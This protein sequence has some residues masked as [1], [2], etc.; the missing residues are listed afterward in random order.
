MS[1][2]SFAP[3][4]FRPDEALVQFKRQLRD[5]RPLAERGAGFELRGKRVV[6]FEIEI[7]APAIMLRLA[8]RP[9]LTP[10]WDRLAL[11]SSAD[12]RKGVDEVRKRLARWTEDEHS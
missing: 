10:E 4:A 9:A 5:L 1:E 7:D 11:R 8:K 6:E 3:P 2:D 12:V